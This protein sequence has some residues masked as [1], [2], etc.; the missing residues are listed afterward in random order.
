M[1][2]QLVRYSKVL[3]IIRS[4]IWPPS[5]LEYTALVRA[6]PSLGIATNAVSPKA[7]A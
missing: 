5:E 2:Q 4:Q 7:S 6:S 1:T 3:E